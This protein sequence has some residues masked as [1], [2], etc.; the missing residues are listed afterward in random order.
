M[1]KTSGARGRRVTANAM[2]LDFKTPF[3]VAIGSSKRSPSEP[4][5][6]DPRSCERT[7]TTVSPKGE[8]IKTP[9]EKH[10]VRYVGHGMYVQ[11]ASRRGRPTPPATLVQEG[12][13]HQFTMSSGQRSMIEF[14]SFMIDRS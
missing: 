12:K 1:A 11:G 9:R 14:S 8:T 13:A 3:N 7:N 6:E 5:C 10:W 2:A 4:L